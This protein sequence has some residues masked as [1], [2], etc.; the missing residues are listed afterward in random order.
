MK[1]IIFQAMTDQHGLQFD[2]KVNNW[3]QTYLSFIK[4]ATTVMTTNHYFMMNTDQFRQLSAEKKKQPQSTHYK[5][6]P[7]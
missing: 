2:V 3:T 5:V 6:R 1:P 7:T 4:S